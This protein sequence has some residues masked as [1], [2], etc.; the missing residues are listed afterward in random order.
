MSRL[1]ETEAFV[2]VVQAGSFA[3]AAKRLGMSSSYASKL[4]TRLEERLGARLLNRSTRKLSLTEAG[5]GFY[6]D[7]AEALRLV[8]SAERSVSSHQTSL[9][10]RLKITLPTS[11]GIEWLSCALSDFMRAH[12]GLLLDVIYLDRFVDLVAEGFDI[13]IRVGEL[14]DS[15]L[16]R[17]GLGRVDH[18][19]LASPGYLQRRGRPSVPA[20]LS[21]HDCL[22]YSYHRAPT[23]WVL[24]RAEERRSVRVS[25]PFVA[26]NGAALAQAAAN[27]AGIVFVPEFVGTD[28]LADGRLVPILPEWG[29]PVPIS[30]L[31]V[32]AQFVPKKTRVFLDYLS[33]KLREPP[34]ASV[35]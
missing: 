28:Y 18:R 12:P 21:D 15:S 8:D 4:V 11:L 25:G 6:R 17:R 5:E 10:G 32:D 24:E 14:S 2:A 9:Q 23:T 33:A 29:R 3:A 31:Y 26:N 19:L 34:W 20:D 16:I 13:A 35:G 22:V 1:V 7:S 27:G 30:A